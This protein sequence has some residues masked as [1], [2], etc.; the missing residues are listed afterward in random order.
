M[1][2]TIFVESLCAALL[3]VLRLLAATFNLVA[4]QAATHQSNKRCDRSAAA[5]AYRIAQRAASQGPHS[6]TGARLRQFSGHGLIATHLARHGNLLHHG[7]AGNHAAHD[8]GRRCVDAEQSASSDCESAQGNRGGRGSGRNSFHDEGPIQSWSNTGDAVGTMTDLG[9]FGSKTGVLCWFTS[10]S[11][12][13]I[14][15]K[16][17]R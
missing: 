6:K 2:S 12:V 7:R 9:D 17:C 4:Q 14:P 3:H 15:T 16:A 11:R 5:I 8:V 10:I 1:A 13:K